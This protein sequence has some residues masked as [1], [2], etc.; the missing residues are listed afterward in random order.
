MAAT[1]TP[2]APSDKL[3]FPIALTDSEAKALF[4]EI[5]K[6]C[7]CTVVGTSHGAV[8][9]ASIKR[10]ALATEAIRSLA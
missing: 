2:V 8:V 10:A 6:G 7:C 1:A 5:F 4:L 3:S 9:E